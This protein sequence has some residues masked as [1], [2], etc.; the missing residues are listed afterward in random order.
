MNEGRDGAGT[1]AD[2]R[3]GSGGSGQRS[4]RFPFVSFLFLSVLVCL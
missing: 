4:L 1:E 3:A 2:S